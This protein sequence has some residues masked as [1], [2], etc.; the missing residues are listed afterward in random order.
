MIAKLISMSSSRDIIKGQ[1]ESGQTTIK[2]G[3]GG[4]KHTLTIEL[5][6]GV[7]VEMATDDVSMQRFNEAARKAFPTVR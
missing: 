5:T 4:I 2:T 3:P 6:E 1:D 7:T